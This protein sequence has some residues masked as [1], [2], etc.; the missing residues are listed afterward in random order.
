MSTIT[1]APAAVADLGKEISEEFGKEMTRA[2]AEATSAGKTGAEAAAW[3]AGRIN[4][5]KIFAKGGAHGIAT[6]LVSQ[7]ATHAGISDPVTRA[8]LQM[9][10]GGTIAGAAEQ[11]IDMTKLGD[12]F[13]DPAKR[14]GA[15]KKA[16]QDVLPTTATPTGG[17][18]AVTY[19][20]GSKGSAFVHKARRDGSGAAVVFP[21][22]AFVNTECGLLADDFREHELTYPTTTKGGGKRRDGTAI[23][24]EHVQGHK[25]LVDATTDVASALRLKP[26]LCPQC[27]PLSVASVAPAPKAKSFW[28]KVDE[29]EAV[30]DCMAA[31]RRHAA[32]HGERAHID[33]DHMEDVERLDFDALRVLCEG[34]HGRV[35][36]VTD[37]SG[38]L[39]WVEMDE[40]AAKEFVIGLDSIGTELTFSN[41]ATEA[42]HHVLAQ[43]RHA[44]EHGSGWAKLAAFGVL[45]APLAYVLWGTVTLAVYVWAGLGSEPEGH[46]FLN[47]GMLLLSYFSAV[48]W[49]SVWYGAEGLSKAFGGFIHP[50]V[51]EHGN[52]AWSQTARS[53]AALLGALMLVALVILGGGHLVGLADTGSIRLMVLPAMFAAVVAYDRIGSRWHD[54]EGIHHLL[55][56]LSHGNIRTLSVVAALLAALGIGPLLYAEYAGA[57]TQFRLQVAARDI[58]VQ[59]PKAGGKAGETED[60][61]VT[62]AYI[63]TPSGGAFRVE[64]VLGAVMASSATSGP[65]CV[66]KGTSIDLPGHTEKEEAGGCATGEVGFSVRRN[67]FGWRFGSGPREYATLESLYF[68]Q[69]REKAEMQKVSAAQATPVAPAVA[70]SQPAA[71]ANVAT[72]AP[73]AASE[74]APAP[75][76]AKAAPP[77]KRGVDCSKLSARARKAQPACQ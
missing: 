62:V 7:V 75:A 56:S 42:A 52:T 63:P 3:I 77:A 59:A 38:A 12:F 48:L 14:D 26:V 76:K 18:A 32:T 2:S 51:D 30:K 20:W 61:T 53:I 39:L 4:W 60:T 16:I 17:I 36:R 58:T 29:N 37:S 10:V 1:G 40:A 74:H 45:A 6:S 33:V 67:P 69:E 19:H 11:A 72:V 55:E 9:I 22:Q 24:V 43:F 31:L 27:F 50:H 5:A 46:P 47:T 13:A 34:M 44:W 15:V 64:D 73:A 35:T 41:K 71:Q 66:P 25:F 57:T 21:G 28:Q 68:D 70:A 49:L 65:V 23:P 8:I 54:S